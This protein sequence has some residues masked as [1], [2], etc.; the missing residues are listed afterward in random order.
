MRTLSEFSSNDSKFV[1]IYSLHFTTIFERRTRQIEE[2][3]QSINQSNL[4]FVKCRLKSYQ[5]R[6]L[7]LGLHKEP[8]LKA[9]RKLFTTNINV[10]EMRLQCVPDMWC[11]DT[12]TA[13]TISHSPS[14]WYSHL[15]SPLS[16]SVWLPTIGHPL[17]KP[18]ICANFCPAL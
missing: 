8:I 16:D 4:V 18:C 2:A 1:Y 11:H 12:E 14:M 5:R 9:R 15:M 10:L 13:R 6:L 17:L 3:S 7:W